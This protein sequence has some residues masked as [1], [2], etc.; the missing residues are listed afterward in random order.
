MEAKMAATKTTA[1]AKYTEGHKDALTRLK[2]IRSALAAHKKVEANDKRNWGFQGDI[3][4]IN[5]KLDEILDF[6]SS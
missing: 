5:G 6:L 4:Y 2:A 1:H 3:S